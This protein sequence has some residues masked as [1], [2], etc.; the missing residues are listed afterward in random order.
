MLNVTDPS[1]NAGRVSMVVVCGLLILYRVMKDH[2]KPL[3]K[4]GDGDGA[5]TQNDADKAAASGSAL[6]ENVD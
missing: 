1:V 6:S 2:R 4:A 5:N 3:P